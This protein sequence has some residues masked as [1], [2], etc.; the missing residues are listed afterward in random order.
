MIGNKKSS[1][2]KNICLTVSSAL[3]QGQKRRIELSPSSENKTVV[4]AIKD[5]GIAPKGNFDVFD[6]TGQVITNNKVKNLPDQRIYVG[7]KKV[8]G[9][10]IGIPLDRVA[11]LKNNYPSFLPLIDKI[12]DNVVKLGIVFLPDKKGKTKSSNFR[13]L[14][15]FDGDANTPPTPYI[16]DW[17]TER[18]NGSNAYIHGGGSRLHNYDTSKNKIP[19]TNK[20]GFW[21]CYGN[22]GSI[23][24]MLD[25]DPIVRINAFLNHLISLLNE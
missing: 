17:D 2:Q 3:D 1:K 5:E 9:G 24:R 6:S 12:V 21:V 22:F 14:L 23:Y 7:P 25:K 4:Q 15:H 8:A 18:K 13:C 19:G 10:A 20:P 11:D 16:L